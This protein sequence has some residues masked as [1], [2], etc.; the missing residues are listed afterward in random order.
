V[1]ARSSVLVAAPVL[2]L[3]ALFAP[4]DATNT[5]DEA[6]L[7]VTLYDG[8]VHEGEA[9]FT[10]EKL[11]VKG[12]KRAKVRYRDVASVS[13]PA[14]RGEAEVAKAKAEHE[15]RVA[16]A[17]DNDA[18]A[19]ARLGEWAQGEGLADEARAAFERAVAIDPEHAAGHKGL[20]HIKGDDGVWAD[21]GP[22]IEARRIALA[23]DDHD[24]LIELARFALRHGLDAHAWS[25]VQQVLH[26]DTYHAKAIELSR[27]F[28]SAYQQK[29][30]MALPVRGRW[31][32]G[33]DTTRHHQLKAWAAYALDIVKVDAEG[34]ANS[35]DGTKLE[36][37]FAWDAPFYAV[38]PGRVVE[39]RE[40]NPDNPARTIPP[41]AAEKHN[42]VSI[43]HGNGEVSWYVHAKNGSIL[44][45]VGD[46]VERGQQLGTIGNSGA[47]AVPHLHF[48]LV[49]FGNISVPWACDDYVLIAPDRTPIPVSRAC[50]REGWTIESVDR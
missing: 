25:I 40:G 8:T 19:W 46:Q 48:T 10:R 22:I 3:A 33:P 43:D 41:G 50:W 27:P 21:G 29:V 14:P 24:G 11:E 1:Q 36:D 26:Q 13:D 7:R 2:A 6:D 28:T 42:G 35:G 44:V 45:K 32:A 20:G 30:Q 9:K 49:A 17:P 34:K 39:V 4:A 16:A 47:S 31:K 37:Y 23:R 12:R 5:S 15:R 18:T 38:A